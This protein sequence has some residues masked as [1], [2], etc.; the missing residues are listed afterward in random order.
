MKHFVVMYSGEI[1]NLS[2][3]S[4]ME[5]YDPNNVDLMFFKNGRVRRFKKNNK[6][7][8]AI[9]EDVTNKFVGYRNETAFW[10]NNFV[11]QSDN[12]LGVN[13]EDLGTPYPVLNE[14]E[15]LA[16]EEDKIILIH[17]SLYYEVSEF[18]LR[19]KY[20]Y[21]PY[22]Q[23]NNETNYELLYTFS[24]E[25]GLSSFLETYYNY[26]VDKKFLNK[27]T[28]TLYFSS[29]EIL[30][31]ILQVLHFIYSTSGIINRLNELNF[32]VVFDKHLDI[33]IRYNNNYDEIEPKY[34]NLYDE[35]YFSRFRLNLIEFKYFL[36][37][38]S[39]D[40]SKI[41][42]KKLII[43][44]VNVFP[45]EE[46]KFLSIEKRL[47]IIE[48]IIENKY[49]I[50]GDLFINTLGEQ[51]ALIKLI[52]TVDIYNQVEVNTFLSYLISKKYPTGNT[53]PPYKEN[54]FSIL[55]KKLK[56]YNDTSKLIVELKDNKTRFI[57]AIYALWEESMFNPY[58]NGGFDT[59]LIDNNTFDYNKN[60]Q[61]YA[62]LNYKSEKNKF[63][64]YEDEYK[65][66]F[67][68]HAD[69]I[70]WI[71]DNDKTYQLSPFP[72]MH[73]YQPITLV[74]Y[75][76]ENDTVIQLASKNGELNGA[77]PL[78]YLKFI[79]D[80][81]DIQDFN[82]K[83]GYVVDVVTTVSG[84]GNISK[85]R[86]LRNLSR[87]GQALIVIE[88][89][90]IGIGVLNFLLN[91]SE[92]CNNSPFCQK[93]K[94]VLFYIE[95]SALVT[96]PIAAAKTKKAAQQVVDQGVIDGWPEDFL[97]EIPGDGVTPKQKIESLADE[98][99]ISI[100]LSKYR[101]QIRNNISLRIQRGDNQF[102]LIHTESQI[103]QL[104]DL[105]F[106]NGLS[107]SDIEGLIFVSCRIEKPI[108]FSEI[109]Q[110]MVNWGTN[111][112]FRKY[113]YKFQSLEEFN[114]FST[115]L[116]NQ[117][118]DWDIPID[119]VRI[120]GSSLRTPN[121]KDVDVAIMIDENQLGKI[122]ESIISRYKKS[123][124]NT[125]EGKKNLKIA[126]ETLDEQIEKG[127]IKNRQFGLK[128]NQKETFMQELYKI[129]GT[130]PENKPLDL[131]IIIKNKNFDTPPYI[132][133]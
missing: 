28:Q 87:L 67:D 43:S 122:K 78:F 80:V 91:F 92:T 83:V 125:E 13:I 102:S 64:I 85:L 60:Y 57:T 75:P 111:I 7:W 30:R 36:Q 110:Q 29:Y 33:N 44:I 73:L 114:T 116:K 19:T 20:V 93:L 5:I 129:R 40:Y 106:E 2:D 118:K 22:N 23:Y 37:Q 105:G 112:K 123:Y 128:P 42:E 89:I 108:S 48:L 99:N 103:N 38:Y 9:F 82:K 84:I 97:D 50:F 126:L 49:W 63:G 61:H 132:K 12:S 66:E 74:T 35:E 55:Y 32:K 18:K 26:I 4:D 17:K 41:D 130:Y 117:L 47:E 124:G 25:L 79:D 98:I 34:H 109:S 1:L 51:E 3:V 127:Y 59:T 90:Q 21:I 15:Y 81:G 100:Y 101:Q 88:S 119:D 52:N 31:D 77:V 8:M 11:I 94:T 115:K 70:Y 14:F 58:R 45:V 65:F 56:N 53:S 104:I 96:D 71:R 72:S 68:I 46:L 95:I 113:P 69:G 62:I 133:I 16:N 120:Q 54:L 76:S 131:S 6:F 10:D 24:N 86:H 39:E 27:N 107:I 121:A